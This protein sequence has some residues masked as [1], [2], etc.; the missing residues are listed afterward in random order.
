MSKIRKGGEPVRQ[1]IL[2]NVGRHPDN[3][4]KE[5]SAHFR[6]TR[7]AVHKHLSRLVDEGALIGSGGTRD[8][9]YKL[10]PLLEWHQSYN[11]ASKPTEDA[12]WRN[13][14]APRIGKLP[15]NVLDVWHYG[16]TEMF[17]NVIDHSGA[18][19]VLI[20]LTK[21]ATMTEMAIHDDGVGI[22]KKIQAAL[23]LLDERHAILELAK[24]KFTTDPRNHSGEGIFFTSRLFDAFQILSG[25]VYFSHKFA[26][27]EDWI[28]EQESPT[29]GTAVWMRI[30]NHTARSVRKIFAK[31]TAGDENVFN[32]TLVPVRMAQY[33]DDKLVSRSQAKRMLVR[34]ERFR[35]VVFDF[36]GVDSIGQAFADE[37]FR[38]FARQH[39]DI[40][41]TAVK[42]NAAVRQ[43]I[44][45]ARGADRET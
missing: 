41:L 12:V 35:V 43:M 37:V 14:I 27:P 5:T 11:L 34:V 6:I 24:G 8:R 36:T 23:G 28:M 31:F 18:A 42:A 40:E 9:R 1:F 10:A 7:Q 22:F 16:F 39:P 32:K 17:N 15:E 13:D 20:M 33:G 25:G 38:V 19:R 45:R 2:A 44:D 30:S 4:T 3:I 26:A 21:T 29:T